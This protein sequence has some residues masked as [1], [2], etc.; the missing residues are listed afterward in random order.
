M[1]GMMKMLG[2]FIEIIELW[3]V[4]QK[5]W[6]KFHSQELTTLIWKATSY[7]YFFKPN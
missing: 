2:F 6:K 5:L 1:V 7:F 3:K 4:M